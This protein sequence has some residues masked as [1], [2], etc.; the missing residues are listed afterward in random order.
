MID[1]GKILY[2][3]VL[4]IVCAALVGIIYLWLGFEH[5]VLMLLAL[6]WMNQLKGR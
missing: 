3:L 4:V 6:M 2:E 1:W 5:A